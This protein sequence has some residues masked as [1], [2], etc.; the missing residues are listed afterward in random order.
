M[1][2][3]IRC[4]VAVAIMTAGLILPERKATAGDIFPDEKLE[5]VIK[6]VLRRQGKEE[7]KEEDLKNVFQ[8]TARGKGIKSLK[9]L[10]KCPRMVLIDFADNE[11]E[12]LSPIAGLTDIQ[13][14]DVSKNAVTD[15]KPLEKLVKLQYVQLEDNKVADLKPLADLKKLSALYLSRNQVDSVEPLKKLTKLSSLYLG[16][17]KVKDIKPLAGL[18][19]LANL[20]L[21]D[22]QIAD[23]SPLTG[24]TDLRFTFL[25]NN[26]IQD[27]APLIEMAK[28]DAA[29]DRRF[30]PY[31]RLYPDGN[32]ID[33]AQ[34]D[35]QIAALKEIGVRINWKPRE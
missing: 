11:I 14:L 12:D 2:R 19:W 13:S 5:A 1:S 8:V 27:F 34:R 7:I 22:N 20:D 35:K 23:I 30:A 10:E 18:K 33:A 28:K 9:G 3:L 24:L 26:Q 15:L 17:N 21:R 4:A 6:D 31:W 16:K 29:G 25:Q 32:P